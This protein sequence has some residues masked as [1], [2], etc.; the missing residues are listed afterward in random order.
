MRRLAFFQLASMEVEWAISD[1]ERFS[2]VIQVEK[3]RGVIVHTNLREKFTDNPFSGEAYE[4]F[5]KCVNDIVSRT[6]RSMIQQG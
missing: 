3:Q 4:T 5:L 2:R 6:S 1:T